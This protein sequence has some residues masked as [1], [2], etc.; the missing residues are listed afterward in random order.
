MKTPKFALL[1]LSLLLGLSLNAGAADTA[2]IFSTTATSTSGDLDLSVGSNYSPSI[3]PTSATATDLKFVGP[4]STTTFTIN[5]ATLDYGTLNDLDATDV[6]TLTNT[7][8][9]AGTI[10]LSSVANSVAPS[11]KDLLYVASGASLTIASGTGTTTLE[12]MNSGNIDNAGT[13]TISGPITGLHSTTA[14]TFTGSG[15]TVLSGGAGG[16]TLVIDAGTVAT[17]GSS[18]S[19]AITGSVTVNGGTLD[20]L[21]R[22]TGAVTF[23]G[24][25]IAGAGIIT[26][27]GASLTVNS[28]MTLSGAN[29]YEGTTTI[30]D[31]ST[32]VL[33]G[34]NA[35]FD[36]VNSG[37]ILGNSITAG[38]GT[39]S[40]G[41]TGTNTQAWASATLNAGAST[42][43]NTVTTDTTTL[44]AITRSAAGGTLDFGSTGTITTTTANANVTGGQQT[45]LG[46]YA[47]YNGET[48]WAVSGTGATAGTITGLSSYNTGFA[49][50]TDV[51]AVSGTSSPASMTINSLRFNNVG[52]YTVNLGGAMTVATGGILETSGV[53]AHFATINNSTLTSG[54]GT[55]LIVI[56][57]NS[58]G[59]L[60]IGSQITGSIGLT[61]SGAGILD[62]SGANN[63]TGV[64]TVNTG[65]LF[66]ATGGSIHST[67]G[68]LV[69]AG[70]TF[71]AA[72]TNAS[73]TAVLTG[74]SSLTFSLGTSTTTQS[75]LQLNLFSSGVSDTIAAGALTLNGSGSVLLTLNDT[76]SDN[77]SGQYALMTWTSGTATLGDFTLAGSAMD[78]GTLAISGD[79]L[80][81][82]AAAVPEP[83][84]WALF[85]GGLVL[86]LACRFRRIACS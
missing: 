59:S 58:N 53:G 74:T 18:T 9:T 23:N 13:L 46:G 7:S 41:K 30:D 10:E 63:Y 52:P 21:Y 35:G 27:S 77:L 15:T 11:S 78:E 4:Y 73:A 38:G 56:Q 5:G 61:K 70:A 57:N 31:N 68:V 20:N 82:N 62:L 44:G 36:G 64:T 43:K 42:I 12:A 85:I 3:T 69:G 24:G 71:G 86:L 76:T 39:L 25:T 34:T 51:D 14:M 37:L 84:T 48:T 45:I 28:T 49:A 83:G 26:G 47:T 81:F 66:L 54:N 80:F 32:F 65:S 60:A 16:V 67:S 17:E 72:T 40:Y 75:N 1:V 50:G 8:A 6:L 22:L 29:G 2:V 19:Q 79:E 55:D 33:T